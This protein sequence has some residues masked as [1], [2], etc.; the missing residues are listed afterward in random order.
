MLHTIRR[1]VIAKFGLFSIWQWPASE[2]PSIQMPKISTLLCEPR[3]SYV[4]CYCFQ[5]HCK[6]YGYSHAHSPSVMRTL[7]IS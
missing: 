7:Q 4:G 2:V 5:Q 1:N 3:T 6:T